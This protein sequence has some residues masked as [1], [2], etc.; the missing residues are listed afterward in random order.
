M[1]AVRYVDLRGRWEGLDQDA[2]VS[3]QAFAFICRTRPQHLS[4]LSREDLRLHEPVI[5]SVR[6]QATSP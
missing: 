3:L 6:R 4:I 2:G 5:C 1:T